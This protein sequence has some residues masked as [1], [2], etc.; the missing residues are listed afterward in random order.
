MTAKPET[1]REGGVRI[2]LAAHMGLCGGVRRAIG[3]AKKR[4]GDNRPVFTLGPIVH[5]EVAIAS[6][7]SDGVR[8]LDRL[9]QVP[10]GSVMIV[11]AHGLPPATL[12][13][14][15]QRPLDLV[16]TTCP[17]VERVRREALAW[18]DRGFHILFLGRHGHAETNTM[19]GALDGEITV[20]AIPEEAAAL[21]T[22]PQSALLCATATPRDLLLRVGE[23]LAPRCSSLQIVDTSCPATEDRQRAVVQLARQVDLLLVVGS[24]TSSN[25][26]RL[27]ETGSRF[28]TC[29]LVADPAT[30]R[31]AW[32]EGKAIVGITAGASAPDEQVE[33]VVRA[34]CERTG[35][36]RGEVETDSL[37]RTDV[38]RI[39][40]DD[41]GVLLNESSPR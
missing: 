10:D 40:P 2:I 23:A 20:V 35:I 29:E 4:A 21:P 28:T 22:Q 3:L 14:A 37:E 8:S 36:R 19:S 39:K 16:D 13:A 11:R 12:A 33:P 1:N 30:L 6:L 34:V 41:P 15:R 17:Y 7:E 9:D 24:E 31:S 27:G 18:R 26:K 5:N 25:T 38:A 32:F